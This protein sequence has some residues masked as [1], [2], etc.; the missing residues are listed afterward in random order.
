MGV[1]RYLTVDDLKHLIIVGDFNVNL[2]NCS[3]QLDLICALGKQLGL[4]VVDPLLFTRRGATLDFALVPRQAEVRID[5]IE[6]VL[7]DHHAIRLTISIPHYKRPRTL[8]ILDRSV[9]SAGTLNAVCSSRNA[10]DFLHLIQKFRKVNKL[11]IFKTLKRRQVERKLFLAL[12]KEK[13]EETKTVLTKY[14]EELIEGNEKLRYSIQSKEVFQFLKKVFKYNQFERRDG[15]IADKVVQ[16]GQVITE[17]ADVNRLIMENLKSIQVNKAYPSY[18]G[19]IPFPKLGCMSKQDVEDVLRRFYHGKAFTDDCI[20]DDIFLGEHRSKVIEILCDLWDGL[21]IHSY[22]F[23]A[24]LIVLNKKHPDVPRPDQIRPIVVTSP[25]VKILEGRLIAK[26]Q[27]Y[28]KEHLHVSQVGFVEQMDIYVNI[29]RA[30]RRINE[31]R[32]KRKRIYCLFLDFSSAYNTVPH[33]LLFEKLRTVL[34]P[35]E[36][37]LIQAIYSR[38]VICLGKEEFRPN[39]GVAQ[40]SVISPSLFNICQIPA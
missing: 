30:L 25:L 20:S 37:Q 17:E 21:D 13:T 1:E 5:T 22:H 15:S 23:R 7:S 4:S 35:E 12:M 10:S 16:D 18:E 39:V 11:R 36:V 19:Y 33:S 26:L 40:G 27:R 31:L 9:A 14:W 32:D 28:L 3:D 2:R 24:R 6:T 8:R 38:T 34:L 29:W